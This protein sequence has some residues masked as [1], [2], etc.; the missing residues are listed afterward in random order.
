ML[1]KQRVT[2]VS[3]HQVKYI[4]RI[5]C[6]D[7]AGIMG[8]E[9][10]DTLVGIATVDGTVMKWN[11]TDLIMIVRVTMQNEEEVRWGNAY[12]QRITDIGVT[13]NYRR[14]ICLAG[15]IQSTRNR[16]LTGSWMFT[17]LAGKWSADGNVPCVTLLTSNQEFMS[18]YNGMVRDTKTEGLL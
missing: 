9:R 15:Y 7:H 8:K 13:R 12:I 11:R 6:P 4:T 1:R 10:D 5:S 17:L 14:Q 18:F 2:L 3:K 16:Y